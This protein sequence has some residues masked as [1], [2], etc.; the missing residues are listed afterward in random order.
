MSTQ[1]KI[2]PVDPNPFSPV[3]NYDHAWLID[4]LEAAFG[5]F[6]LVL[7]RD[8]LPELEAIRQTAIASQDVLGKETVAT[9]IAH[10]ARRGAMEVTFEKKIGVE[11]TPD[12][13]H[14][15]T[16]EEHDNQEGTSTLSFWVAPEGA[17]VVYTNPLCYTIADAA[18]A[19]LKADGKPLDK[20]Y[21]VFQVLENGQPTELQILN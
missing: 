10:I 4:Q 18:H 9:L 2:R 21:M 6:P 8:A 7:G 13:K 19:Q 17:P 14:Q 15:H 5:F 20:W 11:V 3:D 16:V 12:G 1:I